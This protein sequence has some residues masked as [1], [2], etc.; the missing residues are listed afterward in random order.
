MLGYLLGVC[1]PFRNLCDFRHFDG[2]LV[3][4]IG[5]AC[6]NGGILYQN[7]FKMCDDQYCYSFDDNNG[8]IM[9]VLVM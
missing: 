6:G 4:D 7:Y 5:L 3:L 9:V 8:D 1:V 2:S